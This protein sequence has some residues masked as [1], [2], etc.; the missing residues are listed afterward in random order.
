MANC[1]KCKSTS[2]VFLGLKPDGK[3]GHKNA[4]QCL[5]KVDGVDCN[6]EWQ[7]EIENIGNDERRT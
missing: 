7:T 2:I 6:G 3:G 4:W 5:N 1:P